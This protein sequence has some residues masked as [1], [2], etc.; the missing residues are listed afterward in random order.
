MQSHIFLASIVK[1]VPGESIAVSL[2]NSPAI[3]HT[4]MLHFTNFQFMP[5]YLSCVPDVDFLIKAIERTKRKFI[6]LKDEYTFSKEVRLFILLNS[7]FD[8]FLIGILYS[9]TG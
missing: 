1:A 2:N 3:L 6:P 9:V 4:V 5:V 8:W 7:Y